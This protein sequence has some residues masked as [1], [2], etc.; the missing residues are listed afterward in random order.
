M[1]NKLK[2]YWT[3]LTAPQRVQ[4]LIERLN[5]PS[6]RRG[7]AAMLAVIGMN[8]ADERLDLYFEAVIFAL[9]LLAMAADEPKLKD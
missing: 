7:F 2:S 8:I 3:K 4:A 5:Q 6:T 9:A 1:L